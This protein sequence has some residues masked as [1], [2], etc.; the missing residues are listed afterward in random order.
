[1]YDVMKKELSEKLKYN[2]AANLEVTDTEIVYHDDFNIKVTVK[3]AI[4]SRMQS[5]N[6]TITK[7]YDIEV[8]D[9]TKLLEVEII[10]DIAVDDYFSIAQLKE[11]NFMITNIVASYLG[12]TKQPTRVGKDVDFQE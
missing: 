11:M 4:V 6:L 1:M 12:V 10:K 9:V 5:A 2:Y 3:L 8:G 7:H